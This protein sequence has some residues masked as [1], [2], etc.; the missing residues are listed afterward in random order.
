MNGTI[1]V[2]ERNK[3]IDILTEKEIEGFK[4]GEVKEFIQDVAN[5]MD[6]SFG[7][8][9]N[10][11]Y[12]NVK[13]KVDGKL[14]V[15]KEQEKDTNKQSNEEQD[16]LANVYT[17][18]DTTVHV[19]KDNKNIEYYVAKDMYASLGLERTSPLS[20]EGMKKEY[21][22]YIPVKS[23]HGMVK[24]LVTKPDDLEKFLNFIIAKH[25]QEEIK[26]RARNFLNHLQNPTADNSSTEDEKIENSNVAIENNTTNST[27]DSKTT[28]EIARGITK[29]ILENTTVN[30]TVNSTQDSTK[31]IVEENKEPSRQAT[32]HVSKSISSET[33]SNLAKE[34]PKEELKER[35]ADYKYNDI[36]KVKVLK[37]LQYGVLVETQDE[38]NLQGLIHIREIKNGFVTNINMYFAEGDILEAKVINHD[39]RENRLKLS[40]KGFKLTLKSQTPVT[41]EEVLDE[42]TPEAAP[43]NN[44]MAEQLLNLKDKLNLTPSNDTSK[45][46]NNQT[47]KVI[48]ENVT[49]EDVS[50][51]DYADDKTINVTDSVNTNEESV[52][53]VVGENKTINGGDKKMLTEEKKADPNPLSNFEI[54][55]S[56]EIQNIMSRLNQK[57]G[58]I[59]PAAREKLLELLNEKGIVEFTIAMMQVMPEFKADLGLMILNEIEKKANECL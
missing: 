36:V 30:S 42:Y 5:Q 48:S 14:K 22:H 8:V 55:Q 34:E 16:N 23:T 24:S 3:I 56:K 38:F 12:K 6:T 27:Q 59:S 7:T 51:K 25:P 33:N 53:Y 9:H 21:K 52:K 32:I 1:E 43:K 39:K 58:A 41:N 44:A 17:I 35:K 26:G 49:T 20:K 57:V 13:G 19:V 15:N 28:E 54:E 46:P 4:R 50:P 11:Y 37:I 10:I 40:T 18:N 29:Q 45:E 31:P 47:N 2:Q